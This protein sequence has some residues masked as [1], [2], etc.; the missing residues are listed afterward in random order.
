M[1][2]SV[3]LDV[4]DKHGQHAFSLIVIAQMYLF[5]RELKRN[6]KE[7]R[8]QRKELGKELEKHRADEELSRQHLIQIGTAVAVLLDRDKRDV[9]AMKDAMQ[10]AVQEAV[11]EISGVHAKIDPA[12]I[13]DESPTPVDNPARPA[14]PARAKSH[15][16]ALGAYSFVRSAGAEDEGADNGASTASVALA[17]KK[18]GAQ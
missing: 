9:S 3:L 15:P 10:D 4:L 2:F 13:D 11:E 6:H 1:D 5:G 12:Q 14:R 18:E 7:T 8:E 17:E 16:G